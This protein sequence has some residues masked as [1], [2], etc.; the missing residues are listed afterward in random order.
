MKATRITGVVALLVGGGLAHSARNV[1][2]GNGAE[3]AT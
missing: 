3:L 1:G 2:S